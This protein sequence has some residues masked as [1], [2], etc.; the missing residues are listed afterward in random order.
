M[1]Y[2]GHLHESPRAPPWWRLILEAAARGHV[3]LC[4]P[5]ESDMF[6]SKAALAMVSDDANRQLFTAAELE[7]IDRI[8]PWTRLVR[9]GR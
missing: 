1:F 9:P 7:S 2:I 3:K 6:S 8:V 5:L 4:A